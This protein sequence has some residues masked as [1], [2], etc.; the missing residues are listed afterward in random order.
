M[1]RACLLKEI[2]LSTGKEIGVRTTYAY[3]QEAS[4]GIAARTAI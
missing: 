3:I 4:E 1:G 2:V